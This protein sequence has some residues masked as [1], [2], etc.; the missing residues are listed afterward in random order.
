MTCNAGLVN[1]RIITPSERVAHANTPS[2]TP[3]LNFPLVYE[4]RL[5]EL[6]KRLGDSKNLTEKRINDYG[7]NLRNTQKLR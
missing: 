7:S 6:Q 1:P 5:E 4:R 2:V 3:I